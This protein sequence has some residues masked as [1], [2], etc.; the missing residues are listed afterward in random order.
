MNHS[1]KP[2]SGLLALAVLAT[3]VLSACMPLP[4]TTVPQTMPEATAPQ[5][6]SG[7]TAEI[8][9]QGAETAAPQ[10]AEPVAPQGPSPALEGAWWTLVS[11][12]G[13]DGKTIDALPGTEVT[14][15]FQDGNVGG[16]AGCN[17]Y[18]ASYSLDGNQLTVE[19]GGTTMMACEEAIML[20]EAAY[21]I[22]LAS[23]AS[24][25]VSSVGTRK[26]V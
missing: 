12:A 7:P 5:A 10:P 24:F 14:A 22:N 1:T 26:V 13:E 3:I 4:A 17:N 9:P 19:L 16:T 15:R 2:A 23:S 21:L 11:Y 18:F 20:Q 6:T 25:Q 8:V